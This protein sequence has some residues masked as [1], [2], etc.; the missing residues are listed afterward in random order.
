MKNYENI[1]EA[2]E[3]L[4]LY[5]DRNTE[6]LE[7]AKKLDNGEEN[8]REFTIQDL[9]MMNFEVL[10]SVCDLLGMS[11]LYLKRWQS[12]NSQIQKSFEKNTAIQQQPFGDWKMLA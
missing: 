3:D 8:K 1:K 9:Q 5:N 7:V 2:L 12:W 4:L 10:V 11:N 6:F